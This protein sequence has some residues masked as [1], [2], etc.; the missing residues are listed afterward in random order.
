[1]KTG[2]WLSRRHVRW[3][4]VLLA[5]LP[6]VPT[7]IMVNM[8][9]LNAEIEHSM[10][11]SEMEGVYRN[12]LV[13]VA[14]RANL[15]EDLVQIFGTEVTLQL[16][17]PSGEVELQTGQQPTETAISV[18]VE[19]G[20]YKDWT[21][22]LD[23]LENLPNSGAEENQ[24]EVLKKAGWIVLGGFLAAGGVWFVVHRG[25]RVDELRSDMV[26]TV[27]H[28]MKTPVASMK[29]LLETLTDSDFLDENGRAEYLDLLTRENTRLERLAENFLTFS[30]LK[31]G[32]VRTNPKVMAVGESISEMIELIRPRFAEVGG[33]IHSEIAEGLYFRVDR[34]SF[35]ML[36]GNLLENGLKYGGAPPRV[37]IK[38]SQSGR[39]G[40]V[41]VSD[42]G[43]G[44]SREDSRA[45]FRRYFQGDHCLSHKRSGVGLGLAIC[46]RLARL[47][48][49]KIGVQRGSDG[50]GACFVVVL[51][52]AVV[53]SPEIA[54]AG[55]LSNV[56]EKGDIAHA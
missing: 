49:G 50:E 30:R 27:S 36:I 28:E 45:V 38:A 39:N 4:I 48:H 34:E 43:G 44:I 29:V 54:V 56:K 33:E 3:M 11:V 17:K 13:A 47:M 46:D 53:V 8:M 9:L 42:N 10:R 2:L 7:A 18:V 26:T 41:E 40:R 12:Q 19:E 22:K 51:R 1:M 15:P 6:I 5:L 21:V 24:A 32:E 25:L 37:T 16:S 55:E 31:K 14:S 23:G 35:L 52:K 20:F